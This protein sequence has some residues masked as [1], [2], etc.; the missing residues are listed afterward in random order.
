[1]NEANQVLIVVFIDNPINAVPWKIIT[2]VFVLMRPPKWGMVLFVEQSGSSERE[3]KK[4]FLRNLYNYDVDSDVSGT[5]W[6]CHLE[7]E[8][9]I[10]LH[11]VWS[12]SKVR[13]MLF[14]SSPLLIS[15]CIDLSLV[16]QWDLLSPAWLSNI[17]TPEFGTYS[18][19]CVTVLLWHNTTT[20]T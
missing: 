3:W 18:W 14:S 13:W 15:H 9:T 11:S 17:R 7:D 1:M 4:C 16:E 8:T 10:P 19:C 5:T 20:S 2:G 12:V 6:N